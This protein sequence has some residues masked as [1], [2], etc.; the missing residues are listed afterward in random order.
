MNLTLICFGVYMVISVID[1][2]ITSRRIARLAARI[3]AVEDVC[4]A[5][6]VD[7]GGLLV[8]WR[9]G[10]ISAREVRR[11]IGLKTREEDA[12]DLAE[13]HEI[14]NKVG[15]GSCEYSPLLYRKD[16]REKG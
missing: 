14:R 9:A 13:E 16:P 3:D 15:R 1:G 4:L 6:S 7:P 8:L 5:D 10:F 11:L 12:I 2:I